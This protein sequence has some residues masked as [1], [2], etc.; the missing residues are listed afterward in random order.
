MEPEV[1]ELQ[2]ESAEKREQFKRNAK[3]WVPACLAFTAILLIFS[4]LL[5]YVLATDAQRK[6]DQRTIEEQKVIEE[7]QEAAKPVDNFALL[8]SILHD[9]SLYGSELETEEFM[10]AVFALYKE[11]SGDRYAEYYTEEEYR[12]QYSQLSG[13]RV[14]I[15]IAVIKSST[16]SQG[17]DIQALHITAVL[18]GGAADEAGLV[19]GEWIIAVRDSDGVW[20]TVADY[21][22]YEK[23]ILAIQ[24][25]EGSEVGLRILSQSGTDQ[26]VREVVCIRQPVQSE[27]VFGSCLESDPSIAVIRICEFSFQTPVQF[28]REVEKCRQAGAT[29]FVLDVR[30]NSGG[31]LIALRTLLSY[32]LQSGEIV[33]S[34]K[35][36]DG[37]V[38]SILCAPCTYT[39]D[40]EGCNLTEEQIGQYRSDDL[41]F[42]VLCNEGTASAAELFAATLVESGAAKASFGQTTVGK[43]IAQSSM[44]VPF[45]GFKGYIS[46]T[47]YQCLTAQGATYQNQGY[48]PDH[49]VASS[50][51]QDLQLQAALAYFAANS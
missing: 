12:I 13:Q 5:T 4:V 16:S 37:S 47:V 25:E 27:S 24:G 7:Q 28:C 38:Q 18:G 9:R 51:E 8:E 14:G 6:R 19:A 11:Q 49:P 41:S 35:Y 32:F 40:K 10:Q 43:W 20:K 21:G 34:E 33:Y 1:N 26:S 30:N 15:G 39:G 17:Q 31:S 44:E 36:A 50:E 48:T 3:F 46:F 42:V 45:N 23:A 22:N 29:K 2:T